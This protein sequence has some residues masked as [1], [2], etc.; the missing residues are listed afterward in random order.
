MNK[1]EQLYI[2]LE[3]SNIELQKKLSVLEIEIQKLTV[4]VTELRKENLI[5][6][7]ENIELKEKLGLNSTNSSMPSS[8]EL[9]KIKKENK[10]KSDRKQGGQAGHKGY[11]RDKMKADEIIKIDL[12][13]LQCQCDGKI[14]VAKPHVHQKIDIPEIKPYVV[15]YHMQRGRCRNYGKRK[16]TQ[17]P[18]GITGDIFG[19]R[20]KTIISELIGF[21]KNSKREV[22]SM[23]KDIFNIQISLGSISNNE[24]RVATRCNEAYEEIELNLSYS[25]LLHIDETSHYNKG[26]LSWCWLFSNS[27]ASLIKLVASRGMKVLANSVFGKDDQIIISDRYAAY[28]YFAADKRQVCWS[29]LAR[30]FERFANSEHIEVKAIGCYLR[31]AASELFALKKCF[32]R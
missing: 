21:Y 12:D 20:V 9:Y 11:S 16:T 30:D 14:A 23:L 28:N 31:S 10:Q 6:K 1:F 22:E 18:S 25:K 19:A 2:K 26:K 4:E 17:L 24:T 7:R 15:E 8:K 13:S 32:I 3:K 29:H 27:E 5:L